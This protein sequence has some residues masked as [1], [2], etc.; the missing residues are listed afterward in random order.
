MRIIATTDID[1]QERTGVLNVAENG[2]VVVQCGGIVCVTGD[3]LGILYPVDQPG[4][5][6]AAQCHGLANSGCKFMHDDG[7]RLRAEIADIIAGSRSVT[8]D[9]DDDD[10]AQVGRAADLTGA[11]AMETEAIRT[12][13]QAQADDDAGEPG[14]VTATPAP[15]AAGVGMAADVDIE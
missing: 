14:T 9:S 13:L 1:G 3:R 6:S 4:A 10:D 8:D 15:T 7:A 2:V 11:N 5:V 12:A